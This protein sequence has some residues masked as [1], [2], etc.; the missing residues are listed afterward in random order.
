MPE[1]SGRLEKRVQLAVPVEISTLLE[2]AETEH[3]ST[4]D[5]CSNGARVLSQRPKNKNERLMVCS[6][7]GNLR[8]P[9]QVVYC[10]KLPD[11]C[12][13]V[14]LRFVGMRVTEW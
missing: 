14:G 3:T 1:R 11:G 7:S 4:V 9:A 12:F 10:Q 8:A 2:P 13:A 6:I 5:V